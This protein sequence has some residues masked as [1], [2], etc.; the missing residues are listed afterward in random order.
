MSRTT[1][2]TIRWTA[3]LDTRLGMPVLRPSWSRRAA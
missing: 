1:P 3:K 2:L